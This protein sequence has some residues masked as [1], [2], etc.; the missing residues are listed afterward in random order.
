MATVEEQLVQLTAQF[1]ALQAQRQQLQA[2]F[3]ASAERERNA[4][5]AADAL[6]REREERRLRSIAD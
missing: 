6:A 1:G 5:N 2:E 4:D 3:L